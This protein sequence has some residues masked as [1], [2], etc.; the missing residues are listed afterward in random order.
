MPDDTDVVV[1]AHVEPGAFVEG[2]SMLQQRTFTVEVALANGA[3]ASF[4]FFWT[5]E[6]TRVAAYVAPL[7]VRVVDPDRARLL[8]AKLK[9][10]A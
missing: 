9:G 8:G 6:T 10:T 7:Q 5:E 1:H 3:E 2:I 4:A